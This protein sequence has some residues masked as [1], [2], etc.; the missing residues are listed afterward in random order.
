M[1]PAKISTHTVYLIYTKKKEEF[2]LLLIAH[3]L[4]SLRKIYLDQKNSLGSLHST[5]HNRLVWSLVKIETSGKRV[6]TCP[7]LSMARALGQYCRTD[8]LCI[9]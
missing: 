4:T 5:L 8:T 1:N 3:N 7:F 6:V 9:P 2:I